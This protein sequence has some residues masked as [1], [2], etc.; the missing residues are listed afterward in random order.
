MRSTHRY[1]VANCMLSGFLYQTTASPFRVSAPIRTPGLCTATTNFTDDADVVSLSEVLLLS[2]R[3]NSL[4][5]Y[6]IQFNLM[7]DNGRYKQAQIRKIANEVRGAVDGW[8]F[9][10]FV[11][12][13]LS[14]GTSIAVNIPVLSKHKSDTEIRFIDAGGEGSF[15]RNIQS[16]HHDS[17][18][19]RTSVS[20]DRQYPDTY[21]EETEQDKDYPVIFG[22]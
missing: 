4:S 19:G 14:C 22:Y 12:G 3:I 6:Q 11:L 5:L 16:D 20:Q 15:T 18:D 2:D 1:T 17:R 21:V 9:R 7:I 13:T 10:Q 8:G